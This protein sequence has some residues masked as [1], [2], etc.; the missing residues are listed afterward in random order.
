VDPSDFSPGQRSRL[1]R[2]PERGSHERKEVYAILDE[3]FVCHVGLVVEGRPLV[4][5]MLYGRDGD[6]LLLHGAV[7][8]RL[9][10]A[11]A[12]G[13][14]ACITVTLVDGLVV[15]RST[16]HS[17]LNYRSVVAFG[18]AR[19]VEG[20]TQRRQA[21]ERLVEHLIPGRTP[22]ARPSTDGELAATEI[23]EFTI[24]EAT[25]KV[26]RGPPQ[27]PA[28]DRVLPI[29]AGVLPL[30]LAIGA[31]VAAPDLPAGVGLAGSVA[32]W[33]RSPQPKTR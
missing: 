23:V 5:P 19:R 22:E 33:R 28:E 15:A 30:G 24:D 11:L 7:K 29:W 10:N 2:H 26:R 3:G 14:E 25:S 18:R 8:G 21:L 20:G 9:L 17:S 6:R 27:E 16:F 12:G 4:I 32:R 1:Q 13:A 31:P